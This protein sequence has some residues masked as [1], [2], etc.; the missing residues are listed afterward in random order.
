M[1]VNIKLI[2][3]NED[4]IRDIFDLL[5]FK[6]LS[7]MCLVSKQMYRLSKGVLEQKYTTLIKIPY[8]QE[9]TLFWSQYL[10]LNKSFSLQRELY[11]K[12]YR[13]AKKKY[14]LFFKREQYQLRIL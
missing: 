6:D 9:K 2:E 12:F 8:K 7:T 4:A 3:I 1:K 13:I 11:E 10:S 5:S 14:T